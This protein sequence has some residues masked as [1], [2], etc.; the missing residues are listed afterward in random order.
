[1]A[2]LKLALRLALYILALVGGTT[3][4]H[5]SAH[6]IAGLVTG[7]PISEMRIG[8]FG[9]NPGVHIQNTPLSS[10]LSLI[11]YSGGF[12][13]AVFIGVFYALYW[14]RQFSVKPSFENWVMGLLTIEFAG[15]DLVQGY[16]EGHFH[17]AYLYYSQTPFNPLE[18]I[19]LLM[20][21]ISGVAHQ[22]LCPLQKTDVVRRRKKSRR[23]S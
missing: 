1:M 7:V 21:V 22:L 9:I 16:M 23:V 2:K 15:L 13:T 8:F 20:M 14:Y 11:L 12:V 17:A 10:N 18:I 4:I 3:I 6:F 5:E 19:Y